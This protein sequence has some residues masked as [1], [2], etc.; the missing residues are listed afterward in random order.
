MT[1]KNHKNVNMKKSTVLHFS[2]PP[3][4]GVSITP[5][6]LNSV[7]GVFGSAAHG[8]SRI[9]FKL[10]IGHLLPASHRKRCGSG[11]WIL[12]IQSPRP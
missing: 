8:T 12:E 10:L 7:S 4:D 9:F 11:K 6:V 2:I 3:V 1:S 5:S